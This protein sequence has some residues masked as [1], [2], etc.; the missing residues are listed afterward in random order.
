MFYDDDDFT[1]VP[2]G[3][4]RGDVIVSGFEFKWMKEHFGLKF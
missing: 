4:S 3:E 1:C 2:K